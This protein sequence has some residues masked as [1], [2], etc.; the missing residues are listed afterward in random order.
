MSS[1]IK[2]TPPPSFGASFRNSDDAFRT[3]FSTVQ[4]VIPPSYDGPYEVTPTQAVQV[5]QTAN[6]V[7]SS[8][9]VVDP[10]PQ[11]YGLITWNGSVLTVS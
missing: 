11:E 2:F 3:E 4:A 7:P 10:I 5:L 9:I 6:R 1:R 8:D